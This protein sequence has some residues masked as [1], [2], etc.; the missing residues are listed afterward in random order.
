[1]AVYKFDPSHILDCSFYL[2][3]YRNFVVSI[4][5]MSLCI[6]DHRHRFLN[7]SHVVNP[8]LN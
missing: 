5:L 4:L 7:L 1:M 2:N 6:S 8:I 3:R